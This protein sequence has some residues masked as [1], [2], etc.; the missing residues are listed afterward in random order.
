MLM[1]EWL[2]NI[3]L[4]LNSI[5]GPNTGQDWN[6]EGRRP[7]PMLPRSTPYTALTAVANGAAEI[8]TNENSLLPHPMETAK[9]E[10]KEESS[11]HDDFEQLIP[12]VTQDPVRENTFFI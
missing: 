10:I 2:N 12:V 8:A 4:I 3:L 9:E 1:S 11:L 7:F 5:Y 6:R